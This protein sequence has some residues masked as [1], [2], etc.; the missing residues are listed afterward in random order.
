MVG[1]KWFD[2]EYKEVKIKLTSK[3]LKEFKKICFL[4]DL[5][6][7]YAVER[8]VRKTIDKNNIK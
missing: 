6:M 5:T 8:F 1:K 7:Q 3:D 2:G 4:K